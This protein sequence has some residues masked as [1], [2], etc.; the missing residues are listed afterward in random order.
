MDRGYAGDEAPATKWQHLVS[1]SVSGGYRDNVLL[2]ADL[3]QA[4]PFLGVGLD[5]IAWRPLGD[6]GEFQGLVVGDHRQFFDVDS[7]DQEQI[8]LAQA[9][10]EHDLGAEWKLLMP[11]NYLYLDQ[12]LDVS[13]TEVQVQTA[14]VQGHAASLSPSLQRQLSLGTL[15]LE[16]TGLRQFYAS[17]LD[18]SWELGSR[19]G[20]QYPFSGGNRVEAY[21]DF[22]QVWYDNDPQL[23]ADGDPIPGTQRRMQLHEVGAKLR[24]EWGERRVW[25]ATLGLSGRYATDQA[26]HYYDYLRPAAT[27]Q[28]VYRDKGWRLEGTVRGR[29]YAYQEQRGASQDESR[30]RSELALE[31]RG[32]REIL[33]WLQLIAEYT[34]E[35]TFANRPAEAYTVNTVSCGLEILF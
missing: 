23:T 33:S 29:H 12:V 28:L 20:W 13:A 9:R 19:L 21:Y 18:D 10:Y 8:L 31:F 16:L 34:Y 26:S 22:T 27:A 1:V 25:R 35:Q 32:E 6:R 7:A 24:H 4:S 15:E 30:R 11:V 2:S 3:P 17:P 5:L 14:R